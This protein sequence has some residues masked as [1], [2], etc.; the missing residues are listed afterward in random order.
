MDDLKLNQT[1]GTNRGLTD[2]IHNILF[3][4]IGGDEE[5]DLDEHT[6]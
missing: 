5:E 2:T 3:I 1:T 6:F 4:F